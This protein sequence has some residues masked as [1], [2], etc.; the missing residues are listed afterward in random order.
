MINADLR[1]RA[2]MLT[3]SLK[4]LLILTA[5]IAIALAIGLA[6]KTH[7]SLMQKRQSLLEAFGRLKVSNL[8][9]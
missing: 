6:F 7:W 1:Q 2:S 8:T 9:N 3:F 5:I 4:K